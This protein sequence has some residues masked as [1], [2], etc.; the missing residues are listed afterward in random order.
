MLVYSNIFWIKNDVHIR[1]RDKD[2]TGKENYGFTHYIKGI[3]F[4]ISSDTPFPSLAW[5]Y[6]T[7]MSSGCK[8][9]MPGRKEA[10]V[11]WLATTLCTPGGSVWTD[12][13]H[14][15]KGW[16]ILVTTL[17]GN[18]AALT[19]LHSCI[20]YAWV[21]ITSNI[22]RRQSTEVQSYRSVCIHCML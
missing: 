13:W 9:D 6:F 10:T 15:K 5:V 21:K 19:L 18:F 22:S 12:R 4:F 20:L 8:L 14:G 2:E 3:P 7:S 17:P 16:A 11:F 1:C